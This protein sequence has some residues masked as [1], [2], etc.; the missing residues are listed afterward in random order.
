MRNP[1][2]VWLSKR[3]MSGTDGSFGAPPSLPAAPAEV[4]QALLAL[5]APPRARR[6]A[7]MASMAA[8][9]AAAIGLMVELRYDVSYSFASD[10]AID[11]GS[12]T[13]LDL[14]ELEPN[15]YVRVRGTPMLSRLVRYEKALSGASYAV[16]PLAGQRQ[17]FV[18]MP[19]AAIDDP[20]RAAPGEFS[21]RLM[22]FG[23]LGGRF[24]AV[25]DFLARE[26]GMPVTAESFVV[27]TEEPPSAYGW[28]T[29]VL[30]LCLA[31]V[32]LMSGLMLRWFRPLPE[33][34]ATDPRTAAG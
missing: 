15:V 13:A 12:V 11:L 20:M 7:A 34:R 30:A 10:Q 1:R 16:F 26:L 32:A 8:A 5:P 33:A 22:T 3:P 21:G 4:D 6:L 14:S 24:R 19:A 29:F 25:R 31:I 23:Q 9:V 18:Q 28:S 27:L 17:V 2:A